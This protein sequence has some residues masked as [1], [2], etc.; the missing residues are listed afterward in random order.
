VEVNAEL[1]KQPELV[2][3]DP[4]GKGWMLV[5][6]LANPKV[7]DGLR[8]AWDYEKLIADGGGH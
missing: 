5:I 1:P 7:V 8:S 4:Y 2:N 3:T 6:R